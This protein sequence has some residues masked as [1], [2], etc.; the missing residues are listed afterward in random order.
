LG[1]FAEGLR[2]RRVEN[3]ERAIRGELEKLGR[4]THTLPMTRAAILVVNDS[5]PCR[6]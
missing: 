4:H 2:R 5:H 1:G 3:D 6:D